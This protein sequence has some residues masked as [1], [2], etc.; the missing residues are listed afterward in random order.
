MNGCYG[1]RMER[2]SDDYV[3]FVLRSAWLFFERIRFSSVGV[4]EVDALVTP[5]PWTAEYDRS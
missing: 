4:N 1:R 5:H 2:R 3:V